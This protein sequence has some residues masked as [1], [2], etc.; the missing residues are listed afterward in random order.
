[1]VRGAA[2][3]PTTDVYS[4]SATLYYLL[5]GR[6]PFEGSDAASTL[7]RIVSDPPPPLRDQ[8]PE[9]SAELERVVL[10]GLE[11]QAERR[12]QT[13]EE[14]RTALLPFVPGKM[15]F[16]STGIRLAAHMIDQM[17]LSVVN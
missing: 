1:Q 16:G 4:V 12:W 9:V 8:R 7:A 14:L 11:R 13:L 15:S 5:V 6:A 2:L 3:A 10:R 17:V